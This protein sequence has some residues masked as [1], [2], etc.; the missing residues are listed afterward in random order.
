MFLELILKLQIIAF[1]LTVPFVADLFTGLF[2]LGVGSTYEWTHAL[3]VKTETLVELVYSEFDCPTFATP[4][5][6]YN[7]AT[8]K[9]YHWRRP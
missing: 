6:F 7:L 3:F 5:L 8:S 4:D 1:D 2:P 9:K